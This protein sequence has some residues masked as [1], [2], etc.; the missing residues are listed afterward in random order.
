MRDT[1]ITDKFG[2]LSVVFMLYIVNFIAIY[3]ANKFRV[4]IDSTQST[5]NKKIYLNYLLRNLYHFYETFYNLQFYKPH[6]NL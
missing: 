1:C 3:L 6:V 2:V 5:L 4:I